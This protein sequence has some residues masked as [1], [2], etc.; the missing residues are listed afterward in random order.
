M[1]DDAKKDVPTTTEVSVNWE[2]LK[3]FLNWRGSITELKKVE[4]D[5]PTQPPRTK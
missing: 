4:L 1:T 3:R 5:Q 2:G